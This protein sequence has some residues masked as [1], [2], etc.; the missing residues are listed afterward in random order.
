MF[1]LCC[2]YGKHKGDLL[3]AVE[4]NVARKMNKKLTEQE[5]EAAKDTAQEEL[6]D[7]K[8][9]CIRYC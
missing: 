2:A 3:C 8:K 7:Q 6:Q 9:S 4:S 1:F 5:A